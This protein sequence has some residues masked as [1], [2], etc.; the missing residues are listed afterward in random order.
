MKLL[1]F[2]IVIYILEYI[3]IIFIYNIVLFLNILFRYTIFT[4]TSKNI[5]L[6]T[7]IILSVFLGPDEH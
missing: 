2:Y 5:L 4:Y 3:Y 7:G 1:Y 6:I